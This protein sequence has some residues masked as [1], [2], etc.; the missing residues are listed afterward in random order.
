VL[1]LAAAL[2]LIARVCERWDGRDGG[3]GSP[4]PA[5]R[6]AEAGIPAVL[7]A[8]PWPAWAG[9]DE[10]PAVLVLLGGGTAR[11]RWRD[12][13][14]E[15]RPGEGVVV[16]RGG[17]AGDVRLLDPDTVWVA[18]APEGGPAARL[19]AAADRAPG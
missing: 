16:G 1:L 8:G 18:L 12:R 6:R 10:V 15:V 14:V 9:R 4:G 17:F 5:P 13:T 2:A 3:G 7:A 11:L 19:L